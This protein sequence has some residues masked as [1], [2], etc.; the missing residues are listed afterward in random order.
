M[1]VD[2]QLKKGRRVVGY[3]AIV[4]G[5]ASTIVFMSPIFPIGIEAFLIGGVFFGIAYWAL[6]NPGIAGIARRL[7]P[8][9]VEPPGPI[10]P[11]LPVQILRFA[12]ERHGELTVSQVAIELNIPIPEAEAG[13]NACVLSGNATEDYDV[14]RGFALYRFPEFTSPDT[15]PKRLEE[16]GG[17]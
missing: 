11:R 9:L 2:K 7:F 1:Q 8:R 15:E 4:L 5:T 16:G 6:A 12:R 14:R 3:G 13:L 10:A 17:R